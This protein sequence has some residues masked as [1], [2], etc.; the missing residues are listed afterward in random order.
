MKGVTLSELRALDAVAQHG[1]FRAASTA[2]GV[3]TSSL[4]HSV[5]G[6]ERRLGIRLFNRTTR[7]VSLTEGGRSFLDE[8]RP[9]LDLIEAA[10]ESANSFRSKPAG[11][12]RLNSSEAAFERIMPDMLSFLSKY[13]D[14]RIDAV[15][16]GRLVDIVAHGFD[17]GLRLAEAV[18][19]DMIAL[20]LGREEQQI[21]VA[22]PAYLER[23]GRPAKPADLAHHECIRFRHAGGALM[24]WELERHGG[25]ERLDPPGRLILGGDRLVLDA[26]IG[27]AGIAF[28]TA[29]AAEAAL[30]DGRLEQ[31]LPEWT[32][33]FAGLCLY[34][35]RQRA[36]SAGL[37]AFID[38]LRSRRH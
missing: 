26:A 11:T 4:S 33:P 1:S 28:V 2:L 36:T 24:R 34:Y 8:V 17:A 38:H 30:A 14:M 18:P 23:A 10:V 12:L 25:V 19:Q 6:L 22:A 13:P 5:A 16:D 27:G 31:L 37:R 32:P 20:A 15:C 21:L 29:W 9:A 7:S 3:S 35:P